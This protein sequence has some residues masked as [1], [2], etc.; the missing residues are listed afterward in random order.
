MSTRYRKGTL[1]HVTYNLLD[2]GRSRD[3]GNRLRWVR[4]TIEATDGDV[5]SIQE[6]YGTSKPARLA[7][8]TDPASS[9]GAGVQ[10]G[11]AG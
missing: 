7:V 4:E 8:F 5:Y 2:Y 9:L 1:R 3:E 11:A 10:R 6:I